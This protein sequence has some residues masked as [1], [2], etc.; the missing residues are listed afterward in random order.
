[1]V[2]RSH[3]LFMRYD[4]LI[5]P[6]ACL[7]MF[8]RLMEPARNAPTGRTLRAVV[9]HGPRNLKLEYIPELAVLPTQVRVDVRFCGLTASDVLLWSGE[10]RRL[11][12]PGMV[13]GFEVS[14]AIL[15][16][17]G[18]AHERTG[19][20]VGEEVVVHNYPICGG[21]A[22]SCLAHY[23]DVFRLAR[24]VSLKDAVAFADD[25]FSAL[26]AIGRRARIRSGECLLVNARHSPSA[27]AAID[28]AVHVFGAKPIAVCSDAR[29][30]ELCSDLGAMVV[31]ED[32][33]E[34]C[35]LRKING[36][37]GVRVL[38]ETEGGHISGPY[39]REIAKSLEHD[40]LVAFL[41]YARDKR[42]SDLN[43]ALSNYTVFAVAAEHYKLADPLVYRETMQQ[44]LD[45]RAARTIHP[46]ASAIFGLHRVDEA[47]DHYMVESGRKVLVDVKNCD[48]LTLCDKF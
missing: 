36:G 15:E 48:R 4:K 34:R 25:Y 44:L 46:R 16:M 5:N 3:E 41:G 31:F 28:L 9:L 19:Y 20:Q 24:R 42:R 37:R 29:Q 14:G 32:E 40:G 33:D 43:L 47:F 6:A 35:L 1:M 39:F 30:A 2:G 26:L 23:E 21:L 18:L 38:I 22:E 12:E 27:L 17:G 10:H 7:E 11:P 13:L 8:K 45:Y